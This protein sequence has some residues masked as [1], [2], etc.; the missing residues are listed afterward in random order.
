MPRITVPADATNYS[1]YSRLK[2]VRATETPNFVTGAAI[3]NESADDLKVGDRLMGA[4]DYDEII[5][6]SESA[7]LRSNGMQILSEIYVRND[8][9][10]P[11]NAN[12]KY[13]AL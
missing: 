5:K 7:P 4:S 12:L 8:G 11:I 3:Q 13:T 9:A 2:L 1:L 6:E 10:S